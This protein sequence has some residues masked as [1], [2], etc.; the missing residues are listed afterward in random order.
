MNKQI[1]EIK[2]KAV[3]ILKKY[4]IKRAGIFGSYTR[5][6]QKNNS[7]IDM[8]VELDESS[9]LTFFEY[10]GIESQLEQILGKK[11]DLV[12]YKKIRPEL[13]SYILPHEIRI[14]EKNS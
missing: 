3:P 12:Q 1:E 11:V 9:S 10:L 14:Y 4:P 2:K 5:G 13:Q 6:K 8:L 7:D